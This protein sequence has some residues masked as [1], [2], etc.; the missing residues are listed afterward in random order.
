MTVQDLRDL[1][2]QASALPWTFHAH[3]W[4]E[5]IESAD[6]EHVAGKIRPDDAALIVAAVNALP[7][8][9]DATEALATILA[10]VETRRVGVYMDGSTQWPTPL[11]G[12]IARL[13]R[14]ALDRLGETP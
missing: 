5:Q 4:H 1:L 2:N 6:D 8:L 14:D 10:R 7:T 13:A 12:E 9:L 3:S 11:H